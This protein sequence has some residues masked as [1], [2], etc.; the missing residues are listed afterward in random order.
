M[1]GEGEREA[2]V[3]TSSP[4]VGEEGKDPEMPTVVDAQGP[5]VPLQESVGRPN[6]DGHTDAKDDVGMPDPVAEPS[7][8]EAEGAQHNPA[9]DATDGSVLSKQEGEGHD[10]STWDQNCERSKADNGAGA[11]LGANESCSD[12]RGD[13]VAWDPSGESSEE[14]TDQVDGSTE[15][16]SSTLSEGETDREDDDDVSEP[17]RNHTEPATA[18]EYMDQSRNV[19]AINPTKMLLLAV[20]RCLH[21][22][23][24]IRPVGSQAWGNVES[25]LPLLRYDGLY[26]LAEEMWLGT[27]L[28]WYYLDKSAE[29]QG[30]C[31]GNDMLEAFHDGYLTEKSLIVPTAEGDDAPSSTSAFSLLGEIF[32]RMLM[33]V[34]VL[35]SAPKDAHDL[36]VPAASALF[37]PMEGKVWFYIGTSGDVQGPHE[38]QAM[39]DWFTKKMLPADVPVCEREVGKE[40]PQ[41]PSNFQPLGDVLLERQQSLVMEE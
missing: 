3:D 9:V 32:M 18:W 13:P 14:D 10:L 15:E 21:P 16:G 34:H 2:P 39:L 33:L 29:I 24:L 6:D 36:L 11:S 25:Q 41:D 26:P 40:P 31:S 20:N 1:D 35:T 22:Q 37:S 38:S 7:E 23:Q 12:S 17:G 27:R 19:C 8:E 30:P 4:A 28:V 5:A